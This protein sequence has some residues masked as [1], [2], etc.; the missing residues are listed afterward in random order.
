MQT[1]HD[2]WTEKGY[3]HKKNACEEQNNKKIV[4]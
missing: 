4:A 2:G 1:K 3:F